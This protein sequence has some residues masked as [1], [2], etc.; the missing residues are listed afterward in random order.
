MQ[1]IIDAEKNDYVAYALPPLTREE[2]AARAK[3]AIGAFFNRKQQSFLQFVL[4]RYVKVGVASVFTAIL[5]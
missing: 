2:R 3:L 4:A 1:K 5:S